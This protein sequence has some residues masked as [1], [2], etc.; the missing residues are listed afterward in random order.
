MYKV[1]LVDD[2]PAALEGM[3]IMIP[4]KEWGFTICGRCSNGK[5]AINEI[6]KTAP[7]VVVTDIKMPVMDGLKLIEYIR[8]NISDP[9]VII[10]I[11][12]YSEFEYAKKAMEYGVK[13]YLLKPI[14]EEET[15]GI[16]KEINKELEKR[17]GIKDIEKDF[18]YQISANIISKLTKGK[19][20]EE[21]LKNKLQQEYKSKA[22]YYIHIET[23]TKNISKIIEIADKQKKTKK[24]IFIV[25][26]A[27]TSLGIVMGTENK[28][29]VYTFTKKLLK[30]VLDKDKFGVYI[31]IG[32]E[33]LDILEIRRAYTL[34]MKAIE[35]KPFMKSSGILTYE[36]IKDKMITYEF[37]RILYVET[38]FEAL[39]NLDYEKV[40]RIINKVEEEFYNKLISPEIFKMFVINVLYQ[41]MRLMREDEENYK[42]FLSKYDVEGLSKSH[43]TIREMKQILIDYSINIMNHMDNLRDKKAKGVLYDIEGYIKSH[44]YERITL[45]EIAKK[46]YI[47]PVYLGQVFSKT[48]GMSFNEYIHKLRI[49]EAKQLLENTDM[50]LNEIAQHLGYSNYSRFINKFESYL[51]VKPSDYN[52]R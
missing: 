51:K 26:I 18:D 12:A 34:A 22:W 2:E 44:F 49:E 50:K 13:Y 32:N 21:A 25:N 38:L 30:D 39:R 19:Y 48:Y 29:E 16:L 37:E 45:K 24:Y 8:K 5:E 7:H 31:S 11:S 1:L 52:E 10:V 33:V 43:L 46:F 35:F 3:E 42:L 20:V 36:E 28:E 14:I 4:W 17:L 9:I 47:N 41:G 15:L 27:P 40:D 23:G 6:K